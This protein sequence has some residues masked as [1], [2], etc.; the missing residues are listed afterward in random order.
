MFG[1]D[2]RRLHHRSLTPVVIVALN[3]A[4][5][6]SLSGSSDLGYDPSNI[7]AAPT[8]S[9]SKYIDD[10]SFDPEISLIS[11]TEQLTLTG[12]AAA[13]SDIALTASANL[14]VTSAAVT[15]ADIAISGEP[16]IRLS[17]NVRLTLDMALEGTPALSLTGEISGNPLDMEAAPSISFSAQ[18]DPNGLDLAGTPS[19]SISRQYATLSAV[20]FGVSAAATI[21][22]KAEGDNSDAVKVFLNAT[23]TLR[24]SRQAAPMGLINALNATPSMGIGGNPFIRVLPFFT[25]NLAPSPH[26]IWATFLSN[27][28]QVEDVPAIYPE[29]A[30]TGKQSFY[31]SDFDPLFTWW[32]S[33]RNPASLFS[34]WIKLDRAIKPAKLVVRQ[35]VDGDSYK[36][37][38]F[39]LYGGVYIGGSWAFLYETPTIWPVDNVDYEFVFTPPATGYQYISVGCFYGGGSGTSPFKIR[40]LAIY[41]RGSFADLTV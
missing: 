21:Q 14:T 33:T 30:A 27:Y 11:F 25:S 9:I 34:V 10:L 8:L 36:A 38:R 20:P 31:M 6:I 29:N 32:E 22:F 24:I 40:D 28:Y 4:A 19:L 2:H 15:E 41:E 39:R 16:Y 26:K 12:E 35:K 1:H 18:V 13:S 37:L 3:A 23:P 7:E 17:D 5:S